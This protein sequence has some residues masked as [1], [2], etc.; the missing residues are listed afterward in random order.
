MKIKAIAIL[1]AAVFET[2]WDPSVGT[3]SPISYNWTGVVTNVDT[4]FPAGVGLDQT[5]GISLVLDNGIGDQNPSPDVGSYSANPATAPLIL[6]VDIGGD[7]FVGS[8]QDVTVSDGPG[9]NSVE[10]SSGEEMTGQGFDILFQTN[11][12]GILGTDAIPLYIDPADFTVA[13]FS[14]E[15]A[16]AFEEFLP[17]FNGTIEKVATPVPE[18]FTLSLFGAGLAGAAAL[19]R[20]RKKTQKS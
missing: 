1:T 3:A 9:G 4:G 2:L 8:F 14:I 13:T 6:G 11:Q 15:R 10:I 5:I 12:T 7:T 20:R 17:A 16:P 19:R 18:P